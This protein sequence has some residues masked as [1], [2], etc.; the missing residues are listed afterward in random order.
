MHDI[1]YWMVLCDDQVEPQVMHLF[2]AVVYVC[3]CTILEEYPYVQ[4]LV[5]IKQT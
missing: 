1:S 5:A 4:L 2:F 3:V